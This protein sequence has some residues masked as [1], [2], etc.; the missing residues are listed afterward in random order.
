MENDHQFVLIVWADAHAGEGHWDTLDPDDKDE[1]LV[2]TV[3]MLVS[4]Q[5]GGKPNHLTI[6]QSKSPDGFYDHVIHIPVAMRR[7][8]T[9]L[10]PFTKPIDN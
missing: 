7:S 4:E 8:V 6:A 1:H 5:D 3:G 10:T 9:F 2:R